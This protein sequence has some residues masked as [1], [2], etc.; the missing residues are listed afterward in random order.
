[1]AQIVELKGDAPPP[2]DEK[3]P[4]AK[5]VAQEGQ[6]AIVT[7][8]TEQK[9]DAAPEAPPTEVTKEKATETVAKAGLDMDAFSREYAEKGA[10]SPDSLAKLEAAGI[11]RGV[12]DTYIEGQK[13]QASAMQARFEAS[14]GGKDNLSATM[15]WA[16]G[17]LSAAEKAAA[18]AM[19]A[20]GE[21]Q[22][23]LVLAGLNARRLAEVGKEPALVSGQAGSRSGEPGYESTAQ[24]L[25]DM[26]RPEYASDEAFRRKVYQRL[27][28]S[29]N[30]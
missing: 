11:S 10:L 28:A 17:A 13:A 1:M 23:K 18:N 20:A 6:S 25:A 4:V 19:L 16:A 15:E 12:V 30:I 2:K 9:L 29:K 21:D 26:G 27:K 8:N 22:A 24:M 14:V 7:V 3:L 5:L